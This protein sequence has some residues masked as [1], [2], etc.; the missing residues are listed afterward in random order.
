MWVHRDSDQKLT[1]LQIIVVKIMTAPAAQ[2][3]NIGYLISFSQK[4]S[5]WNNSACFHFF[6]ETMYWDKSQ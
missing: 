5:F 2:A 3:E 4:G 6:I 1:A